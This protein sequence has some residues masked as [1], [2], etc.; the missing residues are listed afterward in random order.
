MRIRGA[1]RQYEF[2]QLDAEATFV[3]EDE[4]LEFIGE[5]VLDAAEAVTGSGPVRSAG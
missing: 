3:T 4:V 2:T 5:A 1:D